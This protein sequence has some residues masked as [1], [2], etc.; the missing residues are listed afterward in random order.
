MYRKAQKH[1]K[2]H[3]P[4]LYRASLGHSIEDIE[5]SDELFRDIV[6]TIIGQQLS[7][8]A[9]DTI[10]ERFKGHFK[11]A[12]IT[13]EAIL[14]MPEKTMRAS[15]LSGAK[16]RAIKDLSFKV[17]N[18][19]VNIDR[20]PSMSD[21][22]V[23]YELL[24]VKGIGPWTAEMVLMFSLGRTDVFSPGDLV[25]RKGL[26]SLYRWRNLP[27]AEKIA[28]FTKKWSPYRTYA[29]RILWKIEDGKKPGALRKEY[30][31]K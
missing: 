11:G 4:I 23:L 5:S 28:K 2:K 26:M 1:F 12:I 15:G 3:D 6:W 19:E 21:D 29:A 7:G 13:P 9:A 27:S 10:F 18:G 16:S 8:K 31:G 22:D 25:L 20:L 24:K 14:Q 30:E 17:K